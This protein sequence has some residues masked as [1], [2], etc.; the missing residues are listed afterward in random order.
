[1]RKSLA[2]GL[3]LRLVATAPLAKALS[4]RQ[5][6]EGAVGFRFPGLLTR[7]CGSRVN[8]QRERSD[9]EV[10]GI[11]RSTDSDHHLAQIPRW[12]RIVG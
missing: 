7:R 6:I 10:N 3:L 11:S 9:T 1:V 2:V 4:F 12:H 5:R 8:I